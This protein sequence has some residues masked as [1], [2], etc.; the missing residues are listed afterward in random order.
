MV[1]SRCPVGYDKVLK[2]DLQKT[3]EKSKYKFCRVNH[4]KYCRYGMFAISE[5]NLTEQCQKTR[6]YDSDRL[7]RR[8]K[9]VVSEPTFPDRST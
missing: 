1:K 4:G 2:K 9:R 7:L 3:L 8:V 5:S 6:C